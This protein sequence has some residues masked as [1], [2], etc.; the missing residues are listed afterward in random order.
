MS[1]FRIE[2]VVDASELGN[3]L[4][5]IHGQVSDLDVALIE[6]VPHTKNVKRTKQP[7]GATRDLIIKALTKSDGHA[8]TLADAKKLLDAAGFVG[9][10]IYTVKD[11]LVKKG[12]IEFKNGMMR[13]KHQ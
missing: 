6:S 12:L 2:F 8:M 10:G 7:R 1:R 9:D 3:V 5:K 4:A 11:A 13:L